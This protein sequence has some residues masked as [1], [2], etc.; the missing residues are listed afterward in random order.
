MFIKRKH[1][2][3]LVC[4]AVLSMFAAVGVAFAQE[5]SALDRAL[6]ARWNTQ[7]V[8]AVEGNVRFVTAR[9]M[10]FSLSFGY[11][12]NDD[13]ANIFPIMIDVFYH[14]DESWAVG[15]R[16][17]LFMAHSD[18]RLKR[19]L[20]DHQPTLD[21]EMI[22]EGQLG[23]VEVLASYRPLYGKWTAGVTNLGAF[24]WGIFAGL[25]AVVVDAPNAG[26][27][28]RETTAHFEGVLG[29]DAHVFFY[30][31]L[32]LRLEA[33]L[34]LYQGTDRFLA[35]CFLGVGVSFYLPVGTSEGEEI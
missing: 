33:S 35:P 16:G 31:W 1:A 32:A 4:A 18:S 12:P 15:L 22:Y 17:S 10:A 26:R 3:A 24:D 6:D 30:D 7:E 11:Q 28:E 27:T 13:Y 21:V 34:R 14:I 8:P 25:G 5:E 2:L 9:T 20:E 19:F 29:M 23:D